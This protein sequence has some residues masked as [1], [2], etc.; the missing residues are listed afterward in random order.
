MISILRSI[1]KHGALMCALRG[2]PCSV[3]AGFWPF[4]NPPPY[5]HN[6]VIVTKRAIYCVSTHLRNPLLPL[7]RIHYLDDP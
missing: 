4:F 5:M 1:M 3:H 2:R 7:V 6:D